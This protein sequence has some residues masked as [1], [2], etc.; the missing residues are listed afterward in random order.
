MEEWR[1]VIYKGV[2]F[3]YEISSL[4]RIRNLTT[5]RLL[6]SCPAGAGYLRVNLSIGGVS[7]NAYIHFLVAEAFIGKV[8]KGYVPHHK[9]HNKQ[10]NNVDNLEIKSHSGNR[11][12]DYQHR[13]EVKEAR[14][15]LGRSFNTG[16]GLRIQ[17]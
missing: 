2:P 12:S 5:K 3:T 4:G 9:D 7:F 10:N 11:K 17:K 8:P 15:A 16:V 6:S 13:K 1:Q 14:L